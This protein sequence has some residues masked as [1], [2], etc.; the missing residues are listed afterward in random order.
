L[1]AQF[2]L[3]LESKK[4]VRRGVPHH[5]RHLHCKYNKREKKDKNKRITR[6]K[7]KEEGKNKRKR[8]KKN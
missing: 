2:W 3:Q 1:A 6:R 4:K 5:V 8:E 7:G